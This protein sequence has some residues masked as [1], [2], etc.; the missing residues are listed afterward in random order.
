MQDS[1]ELLD[2]IENEPNEYFWIYRGMPCLILRLP[3]WGT[4]CGYCGVPSTSPF[5]GK[6]YFDNIFSNIEV[7]GDL[8]YTGFRLQDDFTKEFHLSNTENFENCWFL[9]FDCAHG[10]DVCP[11]S[12]FTAIIPDATY[13]DFEYVKHEVESLCDQ[14]IKLEESYVK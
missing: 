8:T 10:Y 7:H 4:Y 9:G 6:H 5:Y 3:A 11:C 14:L 12:P 2:K 1:K 13:K